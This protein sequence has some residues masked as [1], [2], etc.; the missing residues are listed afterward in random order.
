M[1][2]K[3]IQAHMYE[4]IGLLEVRSIAWGL[5]AADAMVKAAPVQ[6]IDTFM[7][8]PGKFVVLVHG[9]PS[10]VDSSLQAGRELA[11]DQVLDSLMLPL[12]HPQVFKAITLE[13]QVKQV[14]ALGFLETATIAA[15]I[16]SADAAA[17]AADVLLLQLHLARGIGG[18]SILTLSGA[19]HEVQAALQAAE[20]V[21]EGEHALVASR[22]VA[23]PHPDLAQQVVQS[24]Q[25]EE[26]AE[27]PPHTE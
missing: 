11:R 22:I 8:T 18:K 10:S 6:F 25:A 14:E 24:A 17:K 27:E 13:S 21:L 15:G 26:A 5:E 20:N 16:R 4:A 19:L 1:M 12:V 3:E 2:A 9:D 7:V 23:N